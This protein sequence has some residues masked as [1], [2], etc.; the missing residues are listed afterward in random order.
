MKADKLTAMQE[1]TKDKSLSPVRL[2]GAIFSLLGFRETEVKLYHLL[3]KE[4]WLN[5]NEISTRLGVSERTT[6]EYLGRLKDKNFIAR[7]VVEE[8]RLSYEYASQLP[9]EAWKNLKVEIRDTI[10][11][12]DKILKEYGKRVKPR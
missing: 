7:R 12:V 9:S 1:L 10:R 8:K 5:V 2:L 3:L 6:R 4:K 11:T